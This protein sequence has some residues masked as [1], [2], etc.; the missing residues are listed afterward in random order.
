MRTLHYQLHY[1]LTQK[2]LR[3]VREEKFKEVYAT[4]TLINFL[5]FS[6]ERG[7]MGAM[8]KDTVG[9]KFRKDVILE[10]IVATKQG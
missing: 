6:V 4:T 10:L 9:F 3:I 2:S 7:P 8:K 1:Q 5:L